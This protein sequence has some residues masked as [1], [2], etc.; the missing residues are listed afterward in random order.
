MSPRTSRAWKSKLSSSSWTSSRQRIILN[1]RRWP[2]GERRVVLLYDRA[3]ERQWFHEIGSAAVCVFIVS[4]YHSDL[5][6]LRGPSRHRAVVV[7]GRRRVSVAGPDQGQS[8]TANV[9][10]LR[11]PPQKDSP[12][13]ETCRSSELVNFPLPMSPSPR[14]AAFRCYRS[15][16]RTSNTPELLL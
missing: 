9:S 11:A 1:C 7:F 10:L 16:L 3:I 4:S 5:G 14:A 15:V 2:E 8:R 13:S 6:L 12:V